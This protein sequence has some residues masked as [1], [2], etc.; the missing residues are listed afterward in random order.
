MYLRP[1]RLVVKPVNEMLQRRRHAPELAKVQGGESVEPRFALGR[2]PDPHDPAVGVGLRP[3]DE[4][5]SFGSV[6]QLDRAMRPEQEVVGDL[7]D[8]GAAPVVVP[9]HGEHQLVLRGADANLTSLPFAPT[10]EAAQ[11][12]TKRE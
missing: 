5:R 6:D 10:L 1:N 3:G 8:R 9:L 2:Q 7:S 11:V 12:G 4:P